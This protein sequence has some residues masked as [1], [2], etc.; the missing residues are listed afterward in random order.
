M[1]EQQTLLSFPWDRKRGTEHRG[2]LA[3]ALA[4]KPRPLPCAMGLT[5]HWLGS[6]AE[7]ANICNNTHVDT[8]AA[9]STLSFS[10][11][12]LGMTQILC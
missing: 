10:V 4:Q 8:K 3:S 12:D 2:S 7:E 9:L 5:K 6:A 11:L 1:S